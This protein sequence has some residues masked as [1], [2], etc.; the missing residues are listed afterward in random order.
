MTAPQASHTS[1][2]PSTAEKYYDFLG[3]AENFDLVPFIELANKVSDMALNGEINNIRRELTVFVVERESILL[4]KISEIYALPL[5]ELERNLKSY[6]PD[7][8]KLKKLAKEISPAVKRS[9]KNLAH[10]KLEDK[11]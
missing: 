10:Y 3:K 1:K 9:E 6:K 4:K 5:P 11:Q 8:E 7:L 2:E